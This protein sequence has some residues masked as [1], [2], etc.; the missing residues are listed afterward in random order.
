MQRSPDC[1]GCGGADENSPTQNF[2]FYGGAKIDASSAGTGSAIYLSQGVDF[3]V[4]LGEGK[5]LALIGKDL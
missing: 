5:D 2:Y 4:H 3:T 1:Q